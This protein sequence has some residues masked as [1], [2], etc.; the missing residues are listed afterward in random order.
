VRALAAF[1]VLALA[2]SLPPGCSDT[3]TPPRGDA[4]AEGLPHTD[5]RTV[6]IGV[7]GTAIDFLVEGCAAR[8][9]SRCGGEIPLSLVFTALLERT[10]TSYAWSFGDGGS[11]TQGSTVSWSSHTY[12]KAGSYDVSLTIHDAAGTLT[13]KKS[14]FVVVEAVSPGGACSSSEVCASGTCVCKASSEGCPAALSSGLCL[15]TCSSSAACGSGLACVDL[16][17][18]A[19]TPA[20]PYRRALCLPS[21]TSD[22]DCT[23]AGFSC[24]LAPDGAGG[25]AW[26]RACLPAIL[27]AVGEPCRTSTLAVDPSVCLG[28]LCLDIGASGSCSAACTKGGCPE[29]SGCVR[30]AG[31]GKSVCLPRCTSKAPCSS[32]PFLACEAPGGSGDLGFTALDSVDEAGVLYCAPKRCT[33]AAECGPGGTCDAARGFCG[34]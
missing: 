4:R 23:R 22:S 9:A 18:G 27:R 7:S 3:A 10:P 26:V 2:L 17:L 32:D 28:G 5:G 11:D 16:S 14:K 6:E 24:A 20:A 8:T 25:I 15:E 34:G 1:S 12:T 13:E 19:G 30:F 31:D 29:E 33:R 21:C